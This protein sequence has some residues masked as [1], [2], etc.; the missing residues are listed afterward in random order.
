MSDRLKILFCFLEFFINSQEFENTD[1]SVII[2]L[3][4]KV[5]STFFILSKLD[6]YLNHNQTLNRLNSHIINLY[7]K[8][9]LNE[10]IQIT[11]RHLVRE[12]K[13]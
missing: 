10:N 6:E 11:F 12:K 3:N 2:S 7:I 4:E 9:K 5:N 1:R 8:Q 13:F